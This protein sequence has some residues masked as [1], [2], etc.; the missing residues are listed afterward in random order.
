MAAECWRCW[1]C[2]G[3]TRSHVMA[4]RLWREAAL[5]YEHCSSEAA[6]RYSNSST[7]T[8]TGLLYGN[9][10]A[11]WPFYR[12]LLFHV[13]IHFLNA[14]IKAHVF[15]HFHH[16]NQ[17]FWKRVDWLKHFTW[18]LSGFYLPMHHDVVVLPPARGPCSLQFTVN[19]VLWWWRLLTI[20]F[21][22]GKMVKPQKT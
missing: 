20:C 15:I 8:H 3:V 22:W 21:S 7:Q 10:K 9:F 5:V 14:I 2:H 19:R 17:D 6:H 4:L 1:T 11:F 16:K 12:V 18:F 13:E